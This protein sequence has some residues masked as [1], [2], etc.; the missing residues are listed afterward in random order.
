MAGNRRSA[1]AT[2]VRT[3]TIR[4]A[5]PSTGNAADIDGLRRNCRSDSTSSATIGTPMTSATTSVP[6][7][8]SDYLGAA[9]DASFVRSAFDCVILKGAQPG[10]NDRGPPSTPA[11]RR[12]ADLAQPV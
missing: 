7:M 4:P 6:F 1:S 12:H 9:T 3:I 8:L 5:A 10:S 11:F 2:C